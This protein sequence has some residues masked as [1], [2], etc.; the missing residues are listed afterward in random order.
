VRLTAGAGEIEM[1]ATKTS[2]PPP[3][4]SRT[5]FGDPTIPEGELTDPVGDPT[6]PEGVLRAPVSVPAVPANACQDPELLTADP[7][8]SSALPEA[9]ILRPAV[10]EVPVHSTL[11]RRFPFVSKV[12]WA[13]A[14][15]DP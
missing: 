9:V 7:A 5:P 11:E 8:T 3:P 2:V 1:L 6:D 10:G 13:A 15:D 12:R 4:V 14:D